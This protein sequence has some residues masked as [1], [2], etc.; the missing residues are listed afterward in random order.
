M[1]Y[2]VIVAD[3]HPVVLRG[4]ELALSRHAIA[5]VVGEAES[6]EGLLA[7]LASTECDALITDFS[8]P[9]PGRDGLDL[10]DEIRRLHPALPVMVITTLANPAL[11]SEILATGVRGLIAKS[12]DCREICDAVR[13]MLAGGVFLGE[14]VRDMLRLPL[15]GSFKK[16]ATLDD[17]S[18]RE[19]KVLRLF[20]S[21]STVTDISRATG[22]GLSTVS[23]QKSSAMR[24]LRLD[25][26]ADVYEYIARL[27]G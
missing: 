16:H 8:M 1:V 6:P 18:P 5:E 19:R 17:L 3:D 25:T 7:V 2:R 26:D 27:R 14:S 24:K 11:Y 20:A 9:G 10:L 23:Q 12:G 4:I 15:G 22:R 13:V 21:G